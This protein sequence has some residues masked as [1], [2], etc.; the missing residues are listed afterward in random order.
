MNVNT[1][2]KTKKSSQLAKGSLNF[3]CSIEK[4]FF[5]HMFQLSRF[6]R[7]APV[8]SFLL[9]ISHFE[10]ILAWMSDVYEFF[11]SVTPFTTLMWKP[12]LPAMKLGACV[13]LG[14]H[15]HYEQE[16]EL[17]KALIVLTLAK[18]ASETSL[19]INMICNF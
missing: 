18:E 6:E 12:W 9:E 15:L 7:T 1:M 11:K 13:A 2:W 3:M 17:I 4:N 19:R 5:F 14:Y 16:T 10:M 8:L